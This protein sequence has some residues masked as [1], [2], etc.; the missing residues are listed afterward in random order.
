[1]LKAGGA[2]VPLDP[3][4]PQSRL[5]YMI[6]DSGIDLILTADLLE[7]VNINAYSSD[8]LPGVSPDSLAYV[9]YT[10]GSTG[11]PKGVMIEHQSAVNFVLGFKEVLVEEQPPQNWLLLTTITFDI[12]LF[13]WV[14]CLS[15]GGNCVV[16]SH[17]QQQDAFALNKLIAAQDIDLI[18]TTPSRWSQLIDAGWQGKAGLVALSGGEALSLEVERGLCDLNVEL[19][20]CYG[21]TEATVWSL[22]NKVNWLDDEQ[23]RLSLGTGLANYQHYVLGRS[24]ELVPKGTIGEL[25]IGGVSLA[26]GYF[27]RTELT[28]ERF[29]DT[30]LGRLYKTGD[31]A[32][33]L[34][35]GKLAFVGRADAQV[36]Y[37]GYRIE[38]GE[39]EY[40]IAQMAEV[41]SSVVLM[42]EDTPGQKVLVAYVVGETA[43]IRQKLLAILPDYMVPS[44]FV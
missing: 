31:L 39:I 24:G 43:L 44:F 16:V 33:Y 21:P 5:D 8:N 15:T 14:G 29:V 4:Y 28:E 34:P 23:D 3:H 38:L 37:R 11:Q 27:D 22:I 35:N 19:Y 18:Q 9:I 32:R 36:K 40:Q 2:Y 25:H 17:E 7:N 13:E 42:R 12:A 10:S 26:R 30:E 1:I 41:K 20:N 6:Q